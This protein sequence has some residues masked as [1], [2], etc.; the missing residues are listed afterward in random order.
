MKLI[1]FLKNGTLRT[2]GRGRTDD[3]ALR[4]KP[5]SFMEPFF[6]MCLECTNHGFDV[7]K[8]FKVF[9]SKNLQEKIKMCLKVVNHVLCVPKSCIYVPGMYKSWF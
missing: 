1:G 3:N 9:I 4:K 5:D 6:K 8:M 7:P 2:N